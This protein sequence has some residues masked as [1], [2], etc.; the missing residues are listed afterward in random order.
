VEKTKKTV[1]TEWMQFGFQ[2][3]PFFI[4]FIIH[5]IFTTISILIIYYLIEGNYYA[6]EGNHFLKLFGFM[7]IIYLI[8][9][10]FFPSIVAF[11]ILQNYKDYNIPSLKH[12]YRWIIFFTNLLLG[13]TGIG[14]LI[15]YF[16]SFIPGNV[17]AEIVT[18]DKYIV[19]D[20][21]VD[22][23]EKPTSDKEKTSEKTPEPPED[24]LQKLADMKEKD[25]INE[26]EF[27]SKKEEILKEL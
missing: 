12:P 3:K 11:D 26:D 13:W 22:K 15:L 14:W 18:F 21:I 23:D 20:G 8:V 5:L 1:E 19:Q 24:R 27:N 4:Y 9:L 25:L 16:W 7:S 10:Y 2:S 6:I 17:L